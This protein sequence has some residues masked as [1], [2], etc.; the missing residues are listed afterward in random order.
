MP[1]VEPGLVSV[2]LTTYNQTRFL[3]DAIESVLAQTYSHHEIIVV[4]DGSADDPTR[5]VSRFPE[6]RLIRQRNQGVATARNT[7]LRHSRGSYVV[8]LDGDDRLLPDALAT[9]VGCLKARPE[10]VLA[11]G[12]YRNIDADGSPLATPAQ[13]LIET[14]HYEALLAGGECVWLPATVMYRRAV[15]DSVAWFDPS[16]STHDDYELYLRLARSFPIQCHGRAIAE[17]RR[18]DANTSRNAALMLRM[19]MAVLRLQRPYISGNRRHQRAY[20][21][22]A[23]MFQQFYGEL[24]IREIRLRR[25]EWRQLTSSLLTLLRHYPQGFARELA[26]KLSLSPLRFRR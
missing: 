18:H 24:L 17:Y 7:G 20:R 6:V 8:F 10:C 14:D 23:R 13:P 25:G 11:A 2:V 15:F 19:A 16:V 4:D 22:G 26:R 5:L 21:K 1:G 3:S 9:G 12:H